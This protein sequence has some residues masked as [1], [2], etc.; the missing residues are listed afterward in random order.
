MVLTSR[1]TPV[2]P[3]EDDFRVFTLFRPNGP[4]PELDYGCPL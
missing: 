2:V 3:S 1:H 4:D